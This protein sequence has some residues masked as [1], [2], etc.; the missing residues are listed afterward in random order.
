MDDETF[1]RFIRVRYLIPIKISIGTAILLLVNPNGSPEFY[2]LLAN[3]ITYSIMV[4]LLYF[5]GDYVCYVVERI[6]RKL[7]KPKEDEP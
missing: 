4:C 2:R 1:N 6:Y 5:V 7:N 3:C